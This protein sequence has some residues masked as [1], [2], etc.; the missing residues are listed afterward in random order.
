MMTKTKTAGAIA[1]SLGLGLASAASHAATIGD[2][3]VKFSGY[4]KA[5]AIASNYSDGTL[6]TKNIGRDFYVPSLTPVGGVDEGTQFDSHI[7]QSRFRFTTTTPTEEGDTIIGVLEFDM[8]VTPAGDDRISNSF[9]PRIRHAFVKY[10]NWT[11]GQTWSTFMDVRVLPETLDFI[12]TT[13]GTIFDRQP[14]V[15]YQSGAWEFALE[16]PETT[17]TPGPNG[18]RI[19]ADDN[20]LPD[21]VVR[22]THSADWGHFAVAAQA[23][24]LSY[25]DGAA[26]DSTEAAYGISLTSKIKLGKHNDIRIAFNTGSG[27][28]RYIALNAANGAVVNLDTNEIEAIDSMGY[29][30]AYRHV[31]NKKMRS[32]F[33]Y[34][35]F[36][37]DIDTNLLSAA[38]TE[39]TYSVRA[40]LI[41]QPTAKISVGGEYAFAKRELA[42]GNDGDMNRLQVSLK[43][44]F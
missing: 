12:G 17:V 16:N 10:K 22:Y 14:L 42:N 21:A 40:N 2:T 4:I 5:D 23:R 19:I 27:L 38:S 7:R 15:R 43:Y 44:A 20:P 24:Q 8:M 41:Y 25:D 33:T 6:P 18:G 3:T 29:S 39:T 37:A 26:I 13:D 32:N 1:L 31:W 30:I 28:G 9:T 36:D 11:V 35:A 34:S